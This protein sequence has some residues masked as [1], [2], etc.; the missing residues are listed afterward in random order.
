MKSCTLLLRRRRK[1]RKKKKELRVDWTNEYNSEKI[2]FAS[3]FANIL[4][5][6]F[7]SYVHLI[8]EESELNFYPCVTH[9][10]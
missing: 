1:K 4:I 5:D 7:L 6:F 2:S 10:I 3:S 9:F 8:R